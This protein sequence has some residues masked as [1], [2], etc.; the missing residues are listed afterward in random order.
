MAELV[1][2]TWEQSKSNTSTIHKTTLMINHL[3]NQNVD[4]S[5]GTLS[6]NITMH[7]LEK[8]NINKNPE[9]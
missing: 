2:V 1:L 4:Y 8:I 6:L 3:T 9:N 7:F 5:F